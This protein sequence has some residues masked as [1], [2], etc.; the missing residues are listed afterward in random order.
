MP[1][2][3]INPNTSWYRR[4]WWCHLCK[5]RP[6][7][8]VKSDIIRGSINILYHFALCEFPCFAFIRIRWII[9]GP[10]DGIIN[11]LTPEIERCLWIPWRWFSYKSPTDEILIYIPFWLYKSGPKLPVRGLFIWGDGALGRYQHWIT[12]DFF[13]HHSAGFDFLDTIRTDI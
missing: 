3:G 10:L 12:Q 9:W 4:A 6:T 1:F 8:F 2:P 7:C 5:L 13:Y 11:W